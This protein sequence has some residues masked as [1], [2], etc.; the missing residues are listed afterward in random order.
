VSRIVAAASRRPRFNAATLSG[1][2][3]AGLEYARSAAC[4][5]SVGPMSAIRNARTA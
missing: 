2:R 3:L 1:G 5:R 4:S